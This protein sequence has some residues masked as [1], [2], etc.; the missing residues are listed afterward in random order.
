MAWDMAKAGP[1]R[2][3]NASECETEGEK[4]PVTVKTSPQITGA[5]ACLLG[6]VLSVSVC[7]CMCVCP[8]VCPGLGMSKRLKEEGPQ[9][10]ASR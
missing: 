6:Q 4:P 7:I 9:A 10:P 2:L 1:E 3:P 8:S 5:V